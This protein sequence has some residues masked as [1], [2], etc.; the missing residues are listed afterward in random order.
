LNENVNPYSEVGQLAL[1]VAAP[2]DSNPSDDAA[3]GNRIRAARTRRGLSVA[4]LASLAGVSKS[5][6]SQIE[7]GIAAPSIDTLRR[8]ASALQLPVFSLFMEEPGVGMVVR[9]SERRVVRYPGSRA[10]REVL[11][12]TLDGRM[13]LLWVTFPPGDEDGREPVKHVGEESVVVV[14]GTLEVNIGPQRVILEAGDS[15]TFDSE[16]PHTFRNPSTEETEIVTAISPPN[17]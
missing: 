16:V 11:S 8:L 9:R 12:P 1:T 7:R 2:A 4:E 17:L 13:V 6:V 14:R 5:L 3:L 10:I 15:M